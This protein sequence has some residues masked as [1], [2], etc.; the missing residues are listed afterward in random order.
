MVPLDYDYRSPSS[1]SVRLQTVP[2]FR[3][4]SGRLMIFTEAEVNIVHAWPSLETVRNRKSHLFRNSDFSD[5]G[6]C[7]AWK[8]PMP[9]WVQLTSLR[10][11]W[12]PHL[13]SCPR[14]GTFGARF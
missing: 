12:T 8:M 11:A 9:T 4:T 3:F 1:F 13:R 10:A 6:Y 2:G 7:Q 14:F 5:R